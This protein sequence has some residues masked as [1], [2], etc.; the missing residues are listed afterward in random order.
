MFTAVATVAPPL[1]KAAPLPSI[2]DVITVSGAVVS[3]GVHELLHAG[4]F[5][6]TAILL[7]STTAAIS[8]LPSPLK[9]PAITSPTPSGASISICCGASMEP[10]AARGQIK[11][12]RVHPVAEP[13]VELLT[14]STLPHVIHTPQ[15]VV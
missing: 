15:R 8:G 11:T 7:R 2:A 10:S 12:P 14:R 13:Q 6:R 9:S 4:S 3:P 5:V 1:G